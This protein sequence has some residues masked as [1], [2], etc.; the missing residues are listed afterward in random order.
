MGVGVAKGENRAIEAAQKAISSPLLEEGNIDGARGVLI[1]FT[2]GSDLTMSEIIEASNIIQEA[3]D[4]DANIIFG[5]VI[6][7]DLIDEI[8]VT[9]IATGFDDISA[10]CVGIERHELPRPAA[11]PPADVPPPVPG[12]AMLTGQ[13]SHPG[14]C[15]DIHEISVGDEFYVGKIQ[16]LKD[17]MDSAPGVY[18]KAVGQ[19]YRNETLGIEDD[20]LDVPTFLRRHA[21]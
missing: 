16:N 4:E 2:G 19:D 1:N 21:D 18:K 20:D 12:E 6:N 5:S 15:S 10:A 14:Q 7:E 11:G 8:H 17:Y 3:A 9:V 13:P